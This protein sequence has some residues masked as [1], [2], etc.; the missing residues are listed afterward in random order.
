MGEI[1]AAVQEGAHGEFAGLGQLRAGCQRQFH[2][3]SQNYRRAVGG[4]LDDVIS[5][6]RMRLLE[7]RDDYF[8]QALTTHWLNHFAESC[9]LCLKRMPQPQHGLGDFPR[10][11]AGEAHH[12]DAAAAGRR[13]GGD[14]SVVEVHQIILWLGPV[15]GAIP[16]SVFFARARCR[17]PCKGG[18]SWP[19]SLRRCGP[20]CCAVARLPTR[21]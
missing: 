17:W 1:D 9:A 7:K 8:V 6:V 18:R 21:P 15:S 16:A 3:A 12:A 10:I 5:G 14:D 20:P 2:D 4:D 13:G 11:R 19:A